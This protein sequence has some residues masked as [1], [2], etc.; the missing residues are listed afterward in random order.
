ML[1]HSIPMVL[2]TSHQLRNLSK[3]FFAFGVFSL[4]ACLAMLMRT[5][6]AKGSG[7]PIP[8][9]RSADPLTRMGRG[10]ARGERKRVPLYRRAWQFF[11]VGGIVLLVAGGVTLLVSLV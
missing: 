5:G 3:A 11:L 9:D 2:A 4:L 6:M 7:E 10:I 8:H 1:T